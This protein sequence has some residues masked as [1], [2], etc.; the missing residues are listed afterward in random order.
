[1]I[2][3]RN[4]IDEFPND[5]ALWFIKWIDE[6]RLPHG[7]TRSASVKVILQRLPFSNPREVSKVGFNDLE[8]I[9][10]KRKIDDEPVIAVPIPVLG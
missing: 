7:L 5:G 2:S 9:L 3:G 1:M 10:G 4:P 8:K 6:F